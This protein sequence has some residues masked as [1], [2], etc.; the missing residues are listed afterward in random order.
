[1]ELIISEQSPEDILSYHDFNDCRLLEQKQPRLKLSLKSVET[2]VRVV[3]EINDRALIVKLLEMVSNDE[4]AHNISLLTSSALTATSRR[5]ASASNSILS[6]GR[7]SLLSS[8]FKLSLNLHS[9]LLTYHRLILLLYLVLS[10][11]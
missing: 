5:R 9:F 6:N 7:V 4:A 8:V 2:Q 3:K 10:W 11:L 1:M